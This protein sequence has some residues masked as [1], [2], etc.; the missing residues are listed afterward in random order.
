M[1][2]A[3]AFVA[4]LA[5]SPVQADPFADAVGLAAKGQHSAA[6]AGF[7]ALAQDG[8]GP[9]AHNLAILFALGHGVPQS[10]PDAT[11]WAMS[12]FLEGLTAAEGLSDV[13]LAELSVDERAQVA[14]R[15]ER[16]WLQRAEAG[17]GG[18]MLALAVVLALIRPEPD[19]LAAHAWQTIA[20]ALDVNGAARA[21]TETLALMSPD[22][23]NMA[24]GHGMTAFAEWCNRQPDARPVSCAVVAMGNG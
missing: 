18:A 20:A 22:E 11:Y 3:L 6:A 14:A 1:T 9:A 21:R 13:L 7:H 8:H 5:A 4:L 24:Q 2:R 17:E 23:R 16:R 15:L 19:L 12:A 10:K